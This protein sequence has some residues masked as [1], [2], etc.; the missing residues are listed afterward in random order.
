MALCRKS[1]L[2]GT[3]KKGRRLAAALWGEGD[4]SMYPLRIRTV[5]F[6]FLVKNAN[7]RRLYLTDPASQSRI[8]Q[9]SSMLS[10][11]GPP[12][13]YGGCVGFLWGSRFFPNRPL[14]WQCR[15]L[16]Y[17]FLLFCGTQGFPWGKLAKISDFWLMRVSLCVL[18]QLH[19]HCC[20]CPHPTSLALG[21]LPPRE[22]FRAYNNFTNYAVSICKLA[23]IIPQDLLFAFT[24]LW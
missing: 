24:V 1:D 21:H 2:A 12:P 13:G 17:I 23:E 22:G 8:F 20:D 16:S 18:S 5:A 19:L 10:G 14:F 4:I 3:R 6:T 7:F 9:H 15:L 11:T